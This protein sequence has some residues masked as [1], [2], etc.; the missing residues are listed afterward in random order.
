MKYTHYEK[1]D[2]QKYLDDHIEDFRNEAAQMMVL[3]NELDRKVQAG[4][5]NALMSYDSLN[6][7][8]VDAN[9]PHDDETNQL[10][11]YLIHNADIT[12][13]EKFIQRGNAQILGKITGLLSSASADYSEDGTTWV[14][15]AKVSEIA[16]QYAN[17]TSA[18]K[19]E[20]D[21]KYEDPANN[22]VK[23]IRTFSE[24]Y[25]EAKRRLD[26]YGETLG[27]PELKGMTA[28]NS[29]EKLAA[30]GTSC[31]FPEYSE[32]LM[33]YALLDAYSYHKKGE[34]VI[35][36]ADLLNEEETEDNESS[37]ETVSTKETPT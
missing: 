13:F 7:F 27:Y 36:K 31:R 16:T 28:E 33:T 2:Y 10:G 6:L 34:P 1:I 11:Y 18:T 32:A 26:E 29:S 8:Y 9:K 20:Y 19:N 5:P 12:F 37:G 23:Y 24:T 14:D 25:T 15:R 22:F 17:A 4:S 30:A 3:V 21:Q 35:N